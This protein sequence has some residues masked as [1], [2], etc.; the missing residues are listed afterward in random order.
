MKLQLDENTLN[1]YITEAIK[2]ELD[3][4][5]FRGK[6]RY[7]VD[8]Q[9]MG[10]PAHPLTWSNASNAGKG[11]LEIGKRAIE[12]VLS[13]EFDFSGIKFTSKEAQQLENGTFGEGMSMKGNLNPLNY[14]DDEKDTKF[15]DFFSHQTRMDK[16]FFQTLRNIGYS[17]KQIYDALQKSIQTGNGPIWVGECNRDGVTFVPYGPK[18]QKKP[19]TKLLKSDQNI[20]NAGTKQPGQENITPKRQNNPAPAQGEKDKGQ[21]QGQTQQQGDEAPVGVIDR[22]N[23]AA[24]W[25]NQKAKEGVEWV[26][27]KLGTTNSGTQTQPQPT[28]QAKPTVDTTQTKTQPVQTAK[29]TQK[30]TPVQRQGAQRRTPPLNSPDETELKSRTLNQN[31]PGALEEI[32]NKHI[33]TKNMKVKLTE[34]TLNAYINEAIKQELDEGLFGKIARGIGKGIK[35]AYKGG[36]WAVK[37]AL[38]K[39]TIQTADGVVDAKTVRNAMDQNLMNKGAAQNALDAANKAKTS[40]AA[41]ASETIRMQA[42]KEAEQLTRRMQ[43]LDVEKAAL[44]KQMQ[45]LGINNKIGQGIVGGAAAGGAYGAGKKAGE[46]K[47]KK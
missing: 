15:S 1:L 41:A 17:D 19:L 39:G 2:K 7:K 14:F 32:K 38:G 36:K 24:E 6:L 4:G 12:G 37:N 20:M 42:E 47:F 11:A 3:E 8:F 13:G 27:K 29:P 40:P 23:Q 22:I 46:N 45:K 43:E 25:A 33:N 26:D 31:T 28:N 18:H 30:T 34:E 16:L 5:I 9:G 35:G 44:Q 10:R 21:P